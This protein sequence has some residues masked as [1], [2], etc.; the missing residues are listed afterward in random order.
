M[1]EGTAAM[2]RTVPLTVTIAELRRG[3]ARDVAERVAALEAHMRRKVE[4]NEPVPLRTWAEVTPYTPHVIRMLRCCWERGGREV[5][6]EVACRAAE[7]SL[8]YARAETVATLQAAIDATR[9][10]M[11]GTVPLGKCKAARAE[12][13][14]VSPYSAASDAAGSAMCE[15]AEGAYNFVVFAAAHVMEADNAAARADILSLV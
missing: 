11:A 10:Y 5:G 4:D 9:G 12:A 2:T 8:R 3:G 14:A 13:W 6:V 7:R 1:Q 15:D